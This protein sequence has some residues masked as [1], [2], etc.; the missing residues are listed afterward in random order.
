MSNHSGAQHILELKNVTQTYT[1]KKTG[2]EFKLFDDLDFA[3]DDIHEK[4][5]FIAIMGESGCGKSTILRYFT[6]LQTPTSGEILIEGK[7]L[8][9]E[10]RIPMVF[11]NPSS[12]EWYSVLKNVALPL[13][14]KG[15]SEK[16]A[17]EKAMAMIEVV[18]LTGHEKKFAKYPLLSGGQ[19]QRVAIARSLVANPT[20]LMMDEP[21]SALDGLNREKMQLFLLDLFNHGELNNL[22]PTIVLVTHDPREAVFLA[23]QIFI[24]GTNPGHVKTRIDVQ[25]P[26]RNNEIRKTQQFLELVN[27]VEDQVRSSI[28]K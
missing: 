5:Q 19:L 15:A 17:N 11:Q 26:Y 20:M 3:I 1:D 9:P 27:F 4:G 25:L 24:M 6:G 12:L 10:D 22:N 23:D 21:F 7:S 14:L 13:I 18:G 28:V 16:E 8:T 2:N